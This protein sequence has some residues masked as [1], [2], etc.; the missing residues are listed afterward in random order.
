VPIP[1][2][3]DTDNGVLTSSRDGDQAV[4]AKY[5]LPIADLYAPSSV[6]WVLQ[7]APNTEGE[8]EHVTDVG[9][10]ITADRV[11]GDDR[12]PRR[13]RYRWGLGSRRFGCS[14]DAAV[15]TRDKQ[16]RCGRRTRRGGGAG[17]IGTGGSAG[18]GGAGSTTAGR[19]P[20]ALRPGRRR[21]GNGRTP[22]SIFREWLHVPR[23]RRCLAPLRARRTCSRMFGDRMAKVSPPPHLV[24][25][26]L[27]SHD[28]RQLIQ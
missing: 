15:A 5:N 13:R 24:Q 14:A 18:A 22:A 21:I 8:G 4:A 6:T 19:A 23:Q 25:S 26:Q 9:F 7:G 11:Y 28:A 2:G 20:E 10:G 27:L 17:A 16:S 1:F 3:T 12:R